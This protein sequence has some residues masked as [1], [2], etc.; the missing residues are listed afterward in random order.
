MKEFILFLI[1][2]WIGRLIY[3]LVKNKVTQISPIVYGKIKK[4]L[5]YYYVI[6]YRKI[7]HLRREAYDFIT[8]VASHPFYNRMGIGISYL[9]LISCFVYAALAFAVKVQ[10]GYESLA[11][12][13]F[14]L[15]YFAFASIYFFRANI[16]LYK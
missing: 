1:K 14:V 2:N 11:K 5:K 10:S 8:T 16:N 7:I 13:L 12:L 3:D 6:K 4:I 15:A 9:F